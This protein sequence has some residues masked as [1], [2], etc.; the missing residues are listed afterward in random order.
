MNYPTL[1]AVTF[2][3]P[4]IGHLQTTNRPNAEV[5]GECETCTQVWTTKLGRPTLLGLG[6]LDLSGDVEEAGG[7]AT[8]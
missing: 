7:A 2:A 6:E 5:L 4:R 3:L 1:D 8:W